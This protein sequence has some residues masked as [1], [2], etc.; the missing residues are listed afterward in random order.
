MMT[1]YFE[2]RCEYLCNVM[3]LQVWMQVYE[4]DSRASRS[5]RQQPGSMVGIA[6]KLQSQQRHSNL[7]QLE[8]TLDKPEG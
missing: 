5:S 6:M 2:Y 3:R 4:E 1:P 7:F 8:L